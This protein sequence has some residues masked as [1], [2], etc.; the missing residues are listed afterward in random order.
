MHYSI[1]DIAYIIVSHYHPDHSGNVNAIK[2][3]QEPR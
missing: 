3:Y 1:N 2:I